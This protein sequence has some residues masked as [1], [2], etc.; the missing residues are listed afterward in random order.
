MTFKVLTALALAAFILHAVPTHGCENIPL[1][2][3][4]VKSELQLL[5]AER[6]RL[7]TQGPKPPISWHWTKTPGLT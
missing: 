3:R 1:S 7:A 6:L 5:E 4:A 2:I